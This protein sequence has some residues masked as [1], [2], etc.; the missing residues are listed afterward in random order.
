LLE[1]LSGVRADSAL[2]SG[3]DGAGGGNLQLGL[4]TIVH[5]ESDALDQAAVAVS[6]PAVV[7][8]LTGPPPSV[9]SAQMWP[10]PVPQA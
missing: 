8:A 3:K 6:P 7:P 9:A 4:R 5:I 10:V 1:L 2:A